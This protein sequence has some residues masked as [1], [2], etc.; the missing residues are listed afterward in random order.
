MHFLYQ[1]FA[2]E[3]V[4][5]KVKVRRGLENKTELHSCNR[6]KCKTV[7]WTVNTTLYGVLQTVY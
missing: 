6:Y 2:F 1:I 3:T 4:C 5:W 7:N